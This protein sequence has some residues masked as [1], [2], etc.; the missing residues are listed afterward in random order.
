MMRKNSIAPQMVF[1]LLTHARYKRILS[2][3][4]SLNPP[5]LRDKAR[6]LLGWIGCTQVPLTIQ[7]IEQAL[8]IRADDLEG[9]ARVL[10]S[11]NIVKICGPIIEVVDGYVQLVH[12]TVKE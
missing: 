6:K 11:L 7:E 10:A 1:I 9:N 4:N 8:I 2:R 3:V 5:T 12:F